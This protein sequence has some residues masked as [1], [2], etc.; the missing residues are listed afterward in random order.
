VTD[1]RLRSALQHTQRA[2]IGL[3]RRYHRVEITG[4]LTAPDRPVL[5]V[6]NHGFG[7]LF[8]LN[9]LMALAAL[10]DMGLERPVTVLVHRL[11]WT[12]GLGPLLERVDACE[13]SA[14]AA[15][16]AFASGQHVLV[17]PGG[18]VDAFKAR[19]DRD[20][21]VFGGRTG[22]ARLAKERGVPIVPIVTAGTG[23]TLLVLSDGQHLAQLL[24]LDRLLRLKAVPVSVSIPWGL[25]IGLVGFLPYL[26]VPVKLR[27][28]VLPPMTSQPE[29]TAE[30]FAAR[31]EEA[32]GRALDRQAHQ[33]RERTE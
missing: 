5:F 15:C 16:A 21:I 27:T 1:D 4:D 24:R 29:E 17:F 19:A 8:D 9:V 22:F 20:R 13:A 23:D 2:A 7:T 11:A 30:D 28:E 31:I 25:N 18:D 12:L 14:E 6:G 3:V 26:S 33:D 10:Q 32:M